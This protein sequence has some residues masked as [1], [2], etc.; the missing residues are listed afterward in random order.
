MNRRPWAVLGL[1][2]L[3]AAPTFLFAISVVAPPA[4]AATTEAVTGSI[5]GPNIV[6][7]GSTTLYQVYGW[8]GPAVAF[9]AT[10]VGTIKYYSA[11]SAS[12]L[13]GV[14]FT[15]ASGNIS[16]NKSVLVDLAVGN[17]TETV[18]IDVMI[19]SLNS[20]ASENK[21]TNVSTTVHVVQPYV[22]SATI[23]NSSATTVSAFVVFVTLDGS[24]VGRVNVTSLTSGGTFQLLYEYPTSG[25]SSG[26]HTFGISLAQE[27]GLVTFA[28]GQ[29]QYTV[30]VYVNGPAPDYTLWYVAGIVAFFGAIFIFASRVA[31]RRRGATR[32]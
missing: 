6:S 1:V 23:V 22:I 15:P 11:L 18:T 14:S 26:E 12:N 21:S 2:L 32:R 27:H 8:G 20:N 7:T 28:N 24:V 3:L 25:L 31:A 4:R 9:N 16:S 10:V 17:A 29:T 19:S 13:T 5:S 30:N